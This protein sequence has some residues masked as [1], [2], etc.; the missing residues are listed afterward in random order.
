MAPGV[1]CE[2]SY[3]GEGRIS[4]CDVVS[5]LKISVLDQLGP[6]RI[7][8]FGLSRKRLRGAGYWIERIVEVTIA[9]LMPGARVLT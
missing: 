7:V 5:L 3:E 8:G 6:T 9:S 1:G 4:V 2:I